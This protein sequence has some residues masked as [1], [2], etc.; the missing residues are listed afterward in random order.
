[1]EVVGDCVASRGTEFLPKYAGI[2]VYLCNGL[3]Y[4]K[5]EACLVLGEYWLRAI[6]GRLSRW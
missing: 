4:P 2:L 3:S 5:R 1:M 6:F